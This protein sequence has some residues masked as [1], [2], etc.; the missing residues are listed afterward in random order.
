MGAGL[1][2]ET[3]L[4]YSSPTFMDQRTDQELIL[5]YRRGED[6]AL[7][8]LIRRHL[9]PLYGFLRRL[10]NDAIVAEDLTQESFIKAWKNLSRFNPSKSFKPWLF[11][12]ARNAAFDYFRKRKMF[13][14]S[15]I[16]DDDVPDFA[17][18]IAD[19]RPLPDEVLVREDIAMRLE[20]ALG[21]LPLKARSV[22]LLHET[23]DMTFQEIAETVMDPLNTVKS[24]YRRALAAL[25][26][27]LTDK[28]S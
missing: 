22:V 1:P 27:T 24:R 4:W 18:V 6:D 26:K 14:F 3:K 19:D 21:E 12:I 10:V 2:W 17:G 11:A 28:T 16:E 20:E 23:E 5:A 13:T 8:T 25:R 9:A 15:E 7:S